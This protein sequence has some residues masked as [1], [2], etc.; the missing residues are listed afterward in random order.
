MDRAARKRTTPKWPGWS[1]KMCVGLVLVRHPPLYELPGKSV[2][3]IIWYMPV[4]LQQQSVETFNSRIWE[5]CFLY[6]HVSYHVYV[7]LAILFYWVAQEDAK[8]LLLC[9]IIDCVPVNP[10][11]P[12]TTTPS[13]SIIMQEFRNHVLHSR[14]QADRWWDA[15]S[16]L[17]PLQWSHTAVQTQ[18]QDT[19][20]WYFCTRRTFRIAPFSFIEMA[21]FFLYR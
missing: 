18:Q 15:S 6:I 11:T 10:S 12:T 8:P 3:R 5:T 21:W 4:E 7:C 2:P 13:C 19:N 16:H 9:I 14:Q 17:R 1:N 20:T